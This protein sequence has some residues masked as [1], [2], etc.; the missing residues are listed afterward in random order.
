MIVSLQKLLE[1]RPTSKI[2]LEITEHC[3]DSSIGCTE[4]MAQLIMEFVEM[5]YG[6]AV[7]LK[8]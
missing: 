3:R 7:Y 2:A 6:Q 4:S 1:N 5:I 8:S